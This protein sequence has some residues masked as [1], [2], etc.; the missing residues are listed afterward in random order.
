MWHYEGACGGLIAQ[1]PT[2]NFQSKHRFAL[3]FYSWVLGVETLPKISMRQPW[4]KKPLAFPEI[5]YLLRLA[6]SE[7]LWALVDC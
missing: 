7:P 4:K 6:S 2:P 1:L 5:A 3:G